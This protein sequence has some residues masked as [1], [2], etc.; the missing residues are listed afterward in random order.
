MIIQNKKI[1]TNKKIK[2]NHLIKIMIPNKIQKEPIKNNRVKF[3]NKIIKINLPKMKN[4]INFHQ[5]NKNNWMVGEKIIK[6]EQQR[7]KLL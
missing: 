2:H 5:L 4:K 6:E 7:K 3:Q 1:L